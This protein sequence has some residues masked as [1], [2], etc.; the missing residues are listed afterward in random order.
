MKENILSFLKN[1]LL[2]YQPRDDYKELLLLA[3]LFLGDTDVSTTIHA[4]GSYHR[5][6]WMGKLIYCFKIYLFR[7]QFK[8][9]SKELNGLQ[10]FNL[11]ITSTYLQAWYTRPSAAS[12]PRQDFQM[13]KKL[14]VYKQLNERVANAALNA[15]R[16]NLWY[17][18]EIT[19]RLAFFDDDVSA[20]TKVLMVVALTREGQDETCK[21]ISTE[22]A[23]I[24]SKQLP[25]FVSVHTRKLFAAL[26]ITEDF[27][28]Q[29]PTEWNTIDDYKL[30]K[31]RVQKLKVVN[32]AAE[33]GVSLVQSFNS[34]LTKKKK[35]KTKPVAGR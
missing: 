24:V 17:I 4:L 8:L 14:V 18:S 5:A 11:F 6:R 21:R 15:F 12:A 1:Q 35:K 7:S 22:D 31:D 19:V 16:R 33:R 30:G 32:D 23:Q 2:T 13:L 26:G 3:I 28:H 29:H 25:D 34:V 10:Q 9:T 27:I 20:E